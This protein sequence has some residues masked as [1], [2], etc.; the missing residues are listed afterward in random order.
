M[1]TLKKDF[2]FPDE[3]TLTRV[4]DKLSDP[5]YKGGNIDLP[6][7]ASEVDRAKYQ[8]CQLIARYQREHNLLQKDLAKKLGIDESRISDILR[9]NI[10]GFTLDRIIGYVEKLYPKL[11]FFIS[12]A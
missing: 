9:G 7:N 3:K 11:K 10:G 1:K 12:A 5:A 2:S 6:E 8:A 4:R